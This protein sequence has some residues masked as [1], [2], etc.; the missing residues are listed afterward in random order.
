[1]FA[2]GLMD[3]SQEPEGVTSSDAHLTTTSV[4]NMAVMIRKP[5]SAIVLD[6]ENESV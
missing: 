4:I 2:V 6:A 1:M 5:T 3:V